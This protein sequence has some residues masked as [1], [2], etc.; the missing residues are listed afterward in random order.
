M[1]Q[2]CSTGILWKM[3]FK[4]AYNYTHEK[5]HDLKKGNFLKYKCTTNKANY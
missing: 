4:D 1:K 5:N 2:E 3:Y